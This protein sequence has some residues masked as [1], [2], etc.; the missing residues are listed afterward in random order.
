MKKQ[1]ESSQEEA[2]EETTRSGR[3]YRPNIDIHEA[4]DGLRLWA[5]LP[6]VSEDSIDVRL[7]DHVLTIEGRVSP[8]DYENLEPTYT[9]YKV[10]NFVRRF[11]VSA[12]VDAEKI[13]AKLR[14]GVLELYLPK[15]QHAQPRRIEI[16]G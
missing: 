14:D 1:Q 13:E 10:G 12:D 3:S 8:A 15:A 6:G 9:E 2:R 11:T 5:D 7:A 4:G 16:H